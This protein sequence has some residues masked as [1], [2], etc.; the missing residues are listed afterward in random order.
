[1][2]FFFV[3][4]TIFITDKLVQ[5]RTNSKNSPN[6]TGIYAGAIPLKVKAESIIVLQY[7]RLTKEVI[8][9]VVVSLLLCVYYVYHI[10]F[11]VF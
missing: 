4:F 1:M 7:L 9:L 6:K 2:S 8:Q 5:A 3:C 11:M 10:S